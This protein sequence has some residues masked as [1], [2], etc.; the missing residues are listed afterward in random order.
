MSVPFGGPSA[1]TFRPVGGAVLVRP[2][3]VEDKRKSGLVLPH[4]PTDGS[5]GRV[6]YGTVVAVGPG[7]RTERGEPISPV[8]AVGD[9]VVCAMGFGDEI[10]FAE[11]PHWLVTRGLKKHGHGVLGILDPGHIH[12][13][14]VEHVYGSSDAVCDAPD[15]PE[16][17][18]S[19]ES[20]RFEPL[21]TCTLKGE[22]LLETKRGVELQR[23]EAGPDSPNLAKYDAEDADRAAWAAKR[24][25]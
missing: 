20:G 1:A 8:C 7:D 25:S 17:R 4:A 2:R 13:W 12:C 5:I 16:P 23:I 19:L 10:Q 24:N 21:L 22:R 14:H 9:E 6:F 18:V 3:P 11:G 15:C